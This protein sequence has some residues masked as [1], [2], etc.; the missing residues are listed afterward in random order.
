MLS[1]S[2]TSHQKTATNEKPQEPDKCFNEYPLEG[3]PNQP[4]VVI[5]NLLS[6]SPHLIGWDD[7]EIERI[8]LDVDPTVGYHD[9]EEIRI[10]PK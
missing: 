1:P 2:T 4:A 5:T 9:E 7:E 6:K 3:D 8:A 10:G